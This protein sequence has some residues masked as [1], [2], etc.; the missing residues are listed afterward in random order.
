MKLTLATRLRRFTL[1]AAT[2]SL[3]LFA[4]SAS[5]QNSALGGVAGVV[6]DS[7]G[8]VVPGTTVTV[9]NTGTGATRT[10]TTNSEG[11]YQAQFL[12]PGTYEVVLGGGSFGKVDRKN[13]PVT[14][15]APTSVD[16]TL[17]LASVTSAVEVTTEVPVL[18]TERVEQSQ[19]VDQAI[20]S[21]VPVSSRRFESFVLLT[22]NV[23]PD[24]SSGLLSY[25]GVNGTYNQNIVDGG[26]NNQAFF[27]EARGRA[28]GAPFVFPV[29]SIR[30]F[31]SSSSGYSAELGG[32]AGGIINAITKS[33]TNEW[34]G[35]VF[36]YYRTPGL[37]A[38]DP[39]TKYNA[40]VANPPAVPSQPV[41][42]QHEFGVS[43]GGPIIK[44]KLFFHFTY[45]G[46]RKVNPITYYT[47]YNSTT[48]SVANLVH[49]CD[50][51]TTN[52]KEVTT[53]AGVTTTTLFPTTIPNVSLA[54]CQAGVAAISGQDGNFSRNAKQDIYFPR[55]DYQLG[56]KTHLSAEFLFENF[57][58][59]NQYTSG[60][61]VQNGGISQNGTA[62]YHER[63]LIASAETALTSRSANVVHFQWARDLE[64]V[65]TNTG[66]PSMS[67]SSLAAFGETN[68]LPRG[69]FPDEH[70]WQGTDIYSHVIGH[71]SLKAGFDV[72]FNHEQIQNLYKGNGGFSYS[73]GT[74]EASYANFL[75]DELGVNPTL[76]TGGGAGSVRHYNSFTQSVDALS[77]SKGLQQGQDDFWNQNIDG[78]VEDSWKVTPTFL[79]ELG[80]RYDAQLVPGPDAPNTTNALT[81]QQTSQINPDL[82]MFQPRVGF[83]WNFQP[84]TVIRGGYGI[85]YGMIGN[86]LFYDVRRENGVYQKQYTAPAPTTAPAP[87]T[88]CASGT[89]CTVAYQN[90]GAYAATNPV[91]GVPIALPPGPAPVNFVTGQ[92]ITIPSS[93]VLPAATIGIYGLD[94]SFKN[95]Q[96]HSID[97]TLEQQLPLHSTLTVGYVGNRALRLPVFVDTNIDPASVTYAHTYQYT[98]PGT[99]KVIGNFTQPIY[100]NKLYA[101]AGEVFSGFSDV[102]SWYNS[103]VATVRKPMSHNIELLANY[104]WA[105][106]MDGGQ[107]YGSNG[108]FGGTDSPIIPFAQ[109]HRQGRGAEYARS[110]LDVRGRF[111]GT[112]VAKSDFALTNRYAAYAVNGWMLGG[113]ITAQSGTP[114]TGTISNGSSISSI[115]GGALGTPGIALNDGDGGVSNAQETSGPSARVPDFIARRNAFSGPGVHNIDARLSRT[116][117]IYHKYS[118]EFAAEAFNVMNHRN[119]FSVNSALVTWTAAGTTGCPDNC[120][121]PRHGRLPWSAGCWYGSVHVRPPRRRASFTVLVSSSSLAAST[122]KQQLQPQCQNGPEKSGPF[123][124]L[125]LHPVDQRQGRRI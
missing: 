116:F 95:P 34:H 92:P 81:Y 72:I 44:D 56:Q 29:E 31:E 53:S 40:R 112:L 19:V 121:E 8:A 35:D 67:I 50:G 93:I 14:V 71:H 5:A 22:P 100:T 59:P 117:P 4:I 32:A 96:S 84:G 97:L 9:I 111:V 52:V 90:P 77:V 11:F 1:A 115:N 2:L 68:A 107:T 37:N 122:S 33:G 46:Y 87:Y 38:F 76:V 13:I 70:K 27:S 99:G 55:L 41:K 120:R 15:G 47:S 42:V 113:T 16:V 17:P 20:I 30:E 28:I 110:D 62:N 75:Q 74:V 82:K 88:T 83:N 124:F 61:T 6:R 43:V 25:R 73:A 3:G 89:T 54:Q 69:K 63:I 98:N 91:G 86:S 79:L 45:D 118:F 109:G 66:G 94:P 106:A 24:G 78:F 85:F 39:I 51:G 101:N 12:Q 103:F 64:T 125:S 26:N 119:I 80:F 7:T 60:P 108:T 48:T 18:D 36:E 102:N 57:H 49:L 104:T 105:K 21:N 114:I 23:V 65:G 58:Q 123:C 10:L